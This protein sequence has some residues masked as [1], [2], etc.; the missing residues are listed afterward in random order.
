VTIVIG[1]IDPE[2]GVPM[3]E[4]FNDTDQGMDA[5]A[6]IPVQSNSAA[7]ATPA[8][9]YAAAQGAAPIPPVSKAAQP[10]TIQRRT[11]GMIAGVLV[12]FVLL[13]GVFA[14]GVAV[15]GRAGGGR[16][17][18]AG[19]GGGN[20]AQAPGGPGMRPGG[21]QGLPQGAPQ[22]APQDAP[23]GFRDS[24]DGADDD[25]GPGGR[26]GRGMMPGQAP[27]APGA[28]PNTAPSTEGTN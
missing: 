27:T 25:H 3:T 17:G 28:A 24:D 21:Q 5:T 6:E 15:G 7:D 2:R 11:L 10:I 1:P 13:G 22:G 12:A 26:R 18:F 9:D 14:A 19:P 23:Q 8:T 20:V 16:D 4:N